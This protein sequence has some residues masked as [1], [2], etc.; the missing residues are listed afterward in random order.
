[1]VSARFALKD[2]GRDF[3]AGVRRDADDVEEVVVY[4]LLR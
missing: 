3:V 2:A 1:V 4:R